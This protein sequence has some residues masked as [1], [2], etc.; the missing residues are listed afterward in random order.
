MDE[1]TDEN[2]DG[3]HAFGFELAQRNIERPLV[4]AGEAEAVIGQ[5]DRFAIRMPVW[6]SSRKTL[7]VC[8][9][10]PVVGARKPPSLL[11][12]QNSS[13]Q[14]LAEIPE[15]YATMVYVAV[16]LGLCVSE[17]IGLRWNDVGETASWSTNAAVVVT[18]QLPKAKPATLR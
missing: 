18:G 4:G 6:R 9:S 16:Y 14:I 10:R 5:V 7:K 17:L 13:K 1:I 11:L 12:L 15:P 3:H 2:I 8:C